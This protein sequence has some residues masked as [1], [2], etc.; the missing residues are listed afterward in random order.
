[1]KMALTRIGEGS[2]MVITGDLSQTDL[3]GGMKSGL[4]DAVEVMKGVKDAAFVEF[5]DGD[6]VR[7]RIVKSIVSAY[8][9]RDR[10]K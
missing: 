6:V 5:E 8:D 9:R 3:P 4:R 1:M 7:S 10:I 2:R